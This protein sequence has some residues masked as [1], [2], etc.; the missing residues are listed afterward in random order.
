MGHGTEQREVGL[1]IG[2]RL[3]RHAV[4]HPGPCPDRFGDDGLIRNDMA[5]V[6]DTVGAGPD[7]MAM[8]ESGIVAQ[9]EG[10]GGALDAADT[11]RTVERAVEGGMLRRRGGSW[12]DV[13]E[14]AEG[15]AFER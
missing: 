11:G 7:A 8:Q 4:Q 2:H 5:G 14:R 6:P 10:H 13:G 1:G 3:E 12:D 9:A 15:S